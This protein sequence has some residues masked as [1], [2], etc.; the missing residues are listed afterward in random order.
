MKTLDKFE[1]MDDSF[2][3]RKYINGEIFYYLG[4]E[5]KLHLIEDKNKDNKKKYAYISIKQDDL[6]MKYCEQNNRKD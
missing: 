3:E 4:K 2:T 6:I 1:Y 5:Y